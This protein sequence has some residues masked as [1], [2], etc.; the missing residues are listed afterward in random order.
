MKQKPTY[1]GKFSLQDSTQLPKLTSDLEALY[2]ASFDKLGVGKAAIKIKAFM[3]L[4]E[5]ER[6]SIELV[7]LHKMLLASLGLIP[8]PF[9]KPTFSK[10]GVKVWVNGKRVDLNTYA[11][12]AYKWAM[13]LRDYPTE[14]EALFMGKTSEEI[15]SFW[16]EKRA[17]R[18]SLFSLT[19]KIKDWLKSTIASK[20]VLI[21][22]TQ[23]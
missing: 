12:D 1:K 18:N 20:A 9:S 6:L 3:P 16:A 7:T 5:F 2:G 10:K 17:E 15:G 21:P 11:L 19:L 23:F 13:L 22:T 8:V 14:L 4:S